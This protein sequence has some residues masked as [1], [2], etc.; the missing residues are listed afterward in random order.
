MEVLKDGFYRDASRWDIA[1]TL[2]KVGKGSRNYMY[3]TVR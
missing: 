3:I 2:I 1:S